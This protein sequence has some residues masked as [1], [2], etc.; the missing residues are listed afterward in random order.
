MI[1]FL[2]NIPRKIGN[3]VGYNLFEFES[4]ERDLGI[5]DGHK[6]L[7]NLNKKLKGKK[8]D[9]NDEIIFQDR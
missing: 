5:S 9:R 2:F 7:I 4:E 1:L 6:Y 8:L 3:L